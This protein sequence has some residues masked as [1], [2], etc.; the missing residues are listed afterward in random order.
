MGLEERGIKILGFGV[1]SEDGISWAM[2]V[3]DFE[4]EAL[5]ALV[6]ECW[7]EFD[8]VEWF[9]A[10]KLIDINEIPMETCAN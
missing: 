1:S 10:S 4:I 2:L 9:I 7:G 5:D 8:E 6:W 3:Q